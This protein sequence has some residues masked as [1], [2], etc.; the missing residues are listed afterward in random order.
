M[1]TPIPDLWDQIDTATG[2]FGFPKIQFEVLAEAPLTLLIS[3][4]RDNRV[5]DLGPCLTFLAEK[6]L[7]RDSDD[8]PLRYRC[9]ELSRLETIIRTGC[10]VVPSDSPIYAACLDKALEYGGYNRVVQ[11]FDPQ[12]LEKTFRKVRKSEAWELSEGFRLTYPSL[13]EMD[14]EWL[15]FS[16]LPPGD[17][18][19]GTAYETEYSFFIPGDPLKALLMV[20]LVGDDPHEIRAAWRNLRGVS[21]G[22]WSSPVGR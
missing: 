15:W 19:I 18:R 13:K 16:K 11:V 20:F 3:L 12:G 22:K 14:G 5:S 8:P 1:S 17:F 21:C 4:P 10:D 9:V 7:R 6:A 2:Y